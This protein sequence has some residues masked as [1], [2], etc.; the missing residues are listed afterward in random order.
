MKEWSLKL[1]QHNNKIEW[2]RNKVYEI[3]VKG[4]NQY[5]IVETMR[6]SQPTIYRD[7]Q[8]LR[9]RA[10]EELRFHIE[11]KLPD[12]YQRCLRGINEVLKIAW[13]IANSKM[14]DRKIDEKTRLQALSLVNDCY[15]FRMDL[16]TNSTV[17]AHAI[18]F[19]ERSKERLNNRSSSDQDANTNMAEKQQTEEEGK[20]ND[21]K[22]SKENNSR[23]TRDNFTTTNQTF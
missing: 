2:R 21:T 16:L 23:E 6:I 8:H 1:N 20:V 13:D 7:V 9:Q 11:E 14:E 17:L 4:Y 22:R 15:K 12:E 5:E 3:L 10:K 19:V 18:S